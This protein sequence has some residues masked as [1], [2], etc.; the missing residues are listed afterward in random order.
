MFVMAA[1]YMW[2]PHNGAQLLLPRCSAQP[3]RTCSG[4]SP[5]L[6][7]GFHRS[8]EAES[9]CGPRRLASCTSKAER[10]TCVHDQN[11]HIHAP[12]AIRR[13][14]EDAAWLNCR[15][16]HPAALL[17]C[18]LRPI[19]STWHSLIRDEGVRGLPCWPLLHPVDRCT[20]AAL[21]CSA[22][23]ASIHSRWVMAVHLRNTS[24][25]RGD[26]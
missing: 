26:A 13:R 3:M 6:Q 22:H 16:Q 5:V 7:V 24:L 1:T 17:I 12:S 9:P 8:F 20:F 23:G 4:T 2:L 19:A 21:W 14:P 11:Y 25:P 18:L 10:K 15:K